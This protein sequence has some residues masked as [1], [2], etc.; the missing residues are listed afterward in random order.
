MKRTKNLADKSKLYLVILLAFQVL[1]LLTVFVGVIALGVTVLT[2]LF[3]VASVPLLLIL[4]SALL[5]FPAIS[6][7][8]SRTFTI[9]WW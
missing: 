1:R 8:R 9:V 7:D 3:A 2:G 6:P 5:I 4:V